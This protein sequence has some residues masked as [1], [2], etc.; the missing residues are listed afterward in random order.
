MVAVLGR[1]AMERGEGIAYYD[2]GVGAGIEVQKGGELLALPLEVVLQRLLIQQI[3][4]GRFSRRIADTPG[5][6]PRH[7]DGSVT[8]SLEPRQ[9]EKRHEV[10]DVQGVSCRIEARIGPDRGPVQ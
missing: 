6:P 8:I 10:P 4:L 3:T 7:N 5:R 2:R 9:S 1:G